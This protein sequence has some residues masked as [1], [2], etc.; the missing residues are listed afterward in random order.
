SNR[1]SS[2]TSHDSNVRYMASSAPLITT[3]PATQPGDAPNDDGE[4]AATAI[5]GTSSESPP[6]PIERPTRQGATFSS[7]EDS[8]FSAPIHNSGGF[9]PEVSGTQNL[10]EAF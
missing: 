5:S 1:F 3:T 7:P 8:S 9:V 4:S 10:K 2:L 6:E